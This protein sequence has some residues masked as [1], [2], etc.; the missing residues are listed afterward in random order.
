M[1]L[2]WSTRAS[3][4]VEG[5]TAINAK[6]ATN[7]QIDAD[8]QRKQERKVILKSEIERQERRGERTFY[9]LNLTKQIPISQSNQR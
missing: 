6:F 4:E 9:P 5:T 2:Q 1:S 3:N 8:L 7:Y